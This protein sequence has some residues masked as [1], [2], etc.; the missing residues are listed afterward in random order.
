MAAPY[1]TASSGALLPIEE[2]PQH[3]LHLGDAG[4]ATHK[5]NVVD[6]ALAHLGVTEAPLHGLHTAAE[7]VF[8]E[9]IKFGAGDG[10]REVDASIEGF[11]L[12]GGLHHARQHPLGSLA[13]C[14]QPPECLLVI[15]DLN[16]PMLPQELP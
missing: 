10:G 11:H 14:F 4:G 16:L 7:N 13:G 12:N 15:P 6:A 2:F 9:L 5:D 3:A 8:V 1:A